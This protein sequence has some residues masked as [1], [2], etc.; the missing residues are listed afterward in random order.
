MSTSAHRAA[1][2][3]RR[4]AAWSLDAAIVA[5][6]MLAITWSRMMA[7]LHEARTAFDALAGRMSGLLLDSLSSSQ[8][9]LSILLAADADS[10]VRAAS[11]T[12]QS[13]LWHAL[14]PGLASVLI[15]AAAYW[16]VCEGAPWQATP[17][18]RALGLRVTDIDGQPIGFGRALAR[19]LAGALSWL[20]LNLGHLLAAVPPQRRALHDF[21]AGTRVL[22][23]EDAGRLPAWAQ[24]WLVLQALAAIASSVWLLQATSSALRS[25]IDNTL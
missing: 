6:P 10:G 19:H 22:Q 24:A 11:A 2:F 15:A 16:I 1:G 3:W 21:I 17:G 7:G 23:R 9:A 18:K 14:Q 20:T 5:L 25:A 13:A 12:L 4:Y 8:D